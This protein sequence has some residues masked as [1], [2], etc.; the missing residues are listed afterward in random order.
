MRIWIKKIIKNISNRLSWELDEPATP[1]L[2]NVV[3][4]HTVTNTELKKEIDKPGKILYTK[5]HV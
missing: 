1:Y 5:P 3:D 2:F 4:Y